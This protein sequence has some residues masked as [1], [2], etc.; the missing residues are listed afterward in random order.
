MA[1]IMVTI[2]HDNVQVKVLYL[3]AHDVHL[4]QQAIV[5]NELLKAARHGDLQ[6]AV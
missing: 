2:H 1:I 4:V 6:S 3:I 5:V